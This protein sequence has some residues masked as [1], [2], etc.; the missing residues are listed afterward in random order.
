M[1]KTLVFL[2]FLVAISLLL[3]SCSNKNTLE[4]T[5][6]TKSEN[7]LKKSIKAVNWAVQAKISWLIMFCVATVLVVTVE[8]YKLLS[9]GFSWR[10]SHKNTDLFFYEN[11]TRCEK[12]DS[13]RDVTKK[14]TL[15]S[16]VLQEC[17]CQN[18]VL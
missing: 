8:K 17:F 6:E 13:K 5:V 12:L 10:F 9:G 18:R 3:K 16:W 7:F 2:A 11:F 1:I 14:K 15:K 4:S